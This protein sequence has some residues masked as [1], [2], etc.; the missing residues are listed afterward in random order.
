M[1]IVD[2]SHPDET[3]LFSNVN[4]AYKITKRITSVRV[5]EDTYALRIHN[6]VMMD[7]IT[8]ISSNN[9]APRQAEARPNLINETIAEAASP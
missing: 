6:S 8:P 9:Q 1:S 7:I 4:T 5:I 3:T 2:D